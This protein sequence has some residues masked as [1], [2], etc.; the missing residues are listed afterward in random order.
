MI[1]DRKVELNV[2]AIY[3]RFQN[4]QI[5]VIRKPYLYAPERCNPL[6]SR[7]SI[8]LRFQRSFEYEHLSWSFPKIDTIFPEFCLAGSQ[9]NDLF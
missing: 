6:I 9:F 1:T 5:L 7:T 4:S 3:V 2:S 8:I